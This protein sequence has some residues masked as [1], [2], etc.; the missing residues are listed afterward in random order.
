MLRRRVNTRPPTRNLSRMTKPRCI[1]SASF[2]CSTPSPRLLRYNDAI[3]QSRPPESHWRRT[4]VVP[5]GTR[6]L[7]CRGPAVAA[8]RDVLRETRQLVRWNFRAVNDDKRTS[9]PARRHVL[10]AAEDAESDRN[11]HG[12]AAVCRRLLLSWN[13]SPTDYLPSRLR[14]VRPFTAGGSCLSASWR[15][16]HFKCGAPIDWIRQ[17]CRWSRLTCCIR[18]NLGQ[19]TH[20]SNI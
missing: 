13:C 15:N 2:V 6:P 3:C 10:G 9:P 1:L 4:L 14:T 16:A 12:K 5:A 11:G 20:D 18:S 7:L 17:I 8:S 19:Q